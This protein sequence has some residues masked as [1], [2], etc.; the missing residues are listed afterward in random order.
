[1]TEVVARGLDEVLSIDGFADVTGL[2]DQHAYCR[3]SGDV[4]LEVG[5][6]VSIPRNHRPDGC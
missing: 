1:M 4:S 5:D 3:V 6:L 2:N